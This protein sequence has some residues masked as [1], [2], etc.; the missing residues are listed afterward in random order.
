VELNRTAQGPVFLNWR[1]GKLIGLAIPTTKI[2]GNKE[3]ASDIVQEI[4]LSLWNRR[5]SIEI[6]GSLA[7]YLYTSVRYKTIH[8]IEKNIT[9][10]DY[11]D[12]LSNLGDQYASVS[13]ELN[14]QAKELGETIHAAIKN[15]P[16]KMKEVY[17]LSREGQLTH[18]QIAERL[19]ISEETVKKHIQHAL[20]LIKKDIGRSSFSFASLLVSLFF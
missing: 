1:F 6:A 8:Y 18:R 13:P 7:A 2:T 9:R 3:D 12:M 17:L 14:L 19:N 20:Q 10:K 4:F 15:M 5:A 16:P 11:A